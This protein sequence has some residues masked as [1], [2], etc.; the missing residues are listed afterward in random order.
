MSLAPTKCRSGARERK[1]QSSCFYNKCS[2]MFTWENWGLTDFLCPNEAPLGASGFR[3]YCRDGGQT[4]ER[5]G[6]ER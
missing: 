3:D 4:R 1:T 6:E 5:K 2:I